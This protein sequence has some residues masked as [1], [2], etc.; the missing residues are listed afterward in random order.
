[1]F[2]LVDVLLK[3]HQSMRELLLLM[4][5]Q[6]DQPEVP[7]YALLAEILQYCETYPGSYHH[8]KEDL[9]FD[10]LCEEAPDAAAALEDLEAEHVVMAGA[11]R[12]LYRLVN[13][14]TEGDAAAADNLPR[15]VGAYLR[16]YR[17]HMRREELEF[18]PLA[19]ETLSHERWLELES[20]VMNPTDPLFEQR[21]RA[22]LLEMLG[23]PVLA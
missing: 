23:K 16:F 4:Q 7:D 15:K 5:E 2:T 9:I 1:M 6:L 17:M 21:A 13:A 12:D 3:E 14:A 22:R 19:L 8:P 20:Q 10:A 11:A 18:F